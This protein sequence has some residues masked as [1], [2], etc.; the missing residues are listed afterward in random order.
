MK[1][2]IRGVSLVLA[3]P[4]CVF[5]LLISFGVDDPAPPLLIAA[6]FGVIF[7]W[8]FISSGVLKDVLKERKKRKPSSDS[9]KPTPVKDF[10]SGMSLLLGLPLCITAYIRSFSSTAPD[11]LLVLSA[12]GGISF[13]WALFSNVII[14]KWREPKKPHPPTQPIGGKPDRPTYGIWDPSI[15]A[16]PLVWPQDNPNGIRI[17]MIKVNSEL[18]ESIGHHSEYVYIRFRNGKAYHY[19]DRNKVHYYGMKHAVSPGAY[20][21]QKLKKKSEG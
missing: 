4:L 6:V 5:A 12:V 21:N 2:I 19:Q 9:P 10:L 13:L 8:A 18:I 15:P 1:D 16:E 14:P 7:L 11:A 3:L 17:D 20:Y